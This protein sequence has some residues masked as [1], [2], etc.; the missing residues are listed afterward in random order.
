MNFPFPIP[1]PEPNDDPLAAREQEMLDILADSDN[2]LDV[3]LIERGGV[4]VVLVSGE[5][6]VYTA[7]SLRERVTEVLARKPEK[8]IVDL[9]GAS[10]LDSTGLGVLLSASRQLPGAVAVVSPRPRITRLFEA[11][12]LSQTLNVYP[13]LADAVRSMTT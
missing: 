12:G 7:N 13:T 4:P 2:P 3:R 10:Y 1:E 11:T 6:D 9:S 5:V 8:L